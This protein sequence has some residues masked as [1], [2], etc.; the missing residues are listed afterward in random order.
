MPNF[1]AISQPTEEGGYACWIEEIPR[2][3]SQSETLKETKA[4][5]M[6]T[7]MLLIELR[8]KLKVSE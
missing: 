1:T 5:L 8:L 7:L 2:A 6:D 4:N 3:N